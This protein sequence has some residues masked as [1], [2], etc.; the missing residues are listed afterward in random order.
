MDAAIDRES[1]AG[2]DGCMRRLAA[3][4]VWIPLSG[5]GDDGPPVSDDE[6]GVGDGDAPDEPGPSGPG[7]DANWTAIDGPLVADQ[8]ALPEF[9]ATSPTS[10]P[11]PSATVEF[12][13]A[14]P[15]SPHDAPDPPRASP[16]RA[17]PPSRAEPPLD[18]ETFVDRYA[19]PWQSRWV[20][21][22]DM[23]LSS[24]ALEA[25]Y[26]AY[27]DRRGDVDST[28]ASGAT[29]VL[30]NY[31]DD[32]IDWVWS[33]PRK[34]ELT[35]CVGVVFPQPI[36]EDAAELHQ[37]RYERIVRGVE[38]AAREWER[39]GDVNFIHLREFDTP[40]SIQ[41]GACQ[42][43]KSGV[44]FRVRMGIGGECSGG[45]A[46]LT[47][48]TPDTEL[49]AE[50]ASP[51]NPGGSKRELLFGV[52]AVA[53]ELEMGLTAPHELGHILGFPHEHERWEQPMNKCPDVG[54]HWRGLTPPDSFSVMGYD[55]CKGIAASQPRLSAYDRLGA[56]YQYGWARRRA[57]IMGAASS[58]EELAYDGTGRPGIG[59]Y[60]PKAHSI[61][62]WTAVGGAGEPLEFTSKARC[63]DG[64]VGPCSGDDDELLRLRPTPLF[65]RGTAADID[66]LLL[67]PG[68]ALPDLLVDNTGGTLN[69]T[70][71]AINGYV[72]PVVG[73]YGDG[74]EDQLL[75]HRPGSDED[76]LLV[77][78][79]FGTSILPMNYPDFAIPL[80]GRFRGF[81]GGGNDIL[82]YQPRKNEVTIW[83]WMDLGEF[84]FWNQGPADAQMLGLVQETEYVPILG[85]FNGDTLTD[86]FWYAP[87][88]ATDWLW[89]SASNQ[90]AVIFDAFEHQVVGEY[91]PLVGDFDGDGVDDIL[92]YS[93]A[94]D[95][96]G[97]TSVLWTFVGDGIHDARPFTIHGDYSP[98]V[99]DFDGD[100]CSDILW[101]DPTAEDDRS[102]IWR[103]LPGEQDFACDAPEAHPDDAYPLGYGGAY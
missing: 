17:S 91:K 77:F 45:C 84:E 72:V 75:L 71:L 25:A 103:C 102:P 46:G 95:L 85:D 29:P 92:W 73:A 23:V 34:L 63:I 30:A 74:L 4:A 11:S 94:D 51:E 57:A 22:G 83:Q 33:A 90:D 99:S 55:T 2:Y 24:A 82:W 62:F 81:G 80:A 14:V 88:A 79:D 68:P 96:E 48:A 13:A 100:G 78:E 36:N 44:F 50:W 60:R 16:T 59:W 65:A 87:G 42:P 53:S 28:G 49:E 40:D 35:W 20:L 5:C 58:V 56:F 67:G 52:R 12:T 15:T 27:L 54:P 9:A 37:L 8:A 93:V 61:D 66:V 101:Y 76:A 38:K 98:M 39:S 41:S 43:G 47:N 21:E 3:L 26:A 7:C 64:G 19:R 89:Q 6:I 1:R 70:P 69:T 86:I 10:P 18:Y 97:G 32:D 31:D